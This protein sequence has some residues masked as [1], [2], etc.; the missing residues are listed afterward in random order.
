M[1]AVRRGDGGVRRRDRGGG[2]DHDRRGAGDAGGDLG[3]WRRR[4]GRSAPAPPR[5][6]TRR[7]SGPRRT[8]RRPRAPRGNARPRL[9]LDRT[10]DV[11]DRR[12]AGHLGIRTWPLGRVRSS[13]PA[14]SATAAGRVGTSS[15]KDSASLPGDGGSG[16]GVESRTS[17]ASK[18]STRCVRPSSSGGVLGVPGRFR[19]SRRRTGS[20]VSGSLP[21]PAAAIPGSR[22]GSSERPLAEAGDDRGLHAEQR[23]ARPG[24]GG[25]DRWR[26]GAGRDRP[27]PGAA[28]RDPCDDSSMI[29]RGVAW[30][31]DRGAGLHHGRR[32]VLRLLL[33]RRAGQPGTERGQP[34]LQ[35]LQVGALLR[36]GSVRTTGA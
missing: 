3:G 10:R 14:R 1:G 22:A 20:G 33:I 35:S 2:G 27:G 6:S 36:A 24:E 12:R 21:P 17:E 11:E 26:R 16:G 13:V 9:A 25:A 28:A 15:K 8:R 29:A 34:A 5:N 4:R 32:L 31:G 7:R 23:L 19:L 18:R 30:I